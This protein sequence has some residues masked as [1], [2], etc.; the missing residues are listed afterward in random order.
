MKETFGVE[1]GVPLVPAIEGELRRV[2]RA[3]RVVGRERR[4]LV[5]PSCAGLARGVDAMSGLR[6]VLQRLGRER[7]ARRDVAEVTDHARVDA[8]VRHRRFPERADHVDVTRR[9]D[10]REERAKLGERDPRKDAYRA[11]AALEEPVRD[12]GERSLRLPENVIERDETERAHDERDHRVSPALHLAARVERAAHRRLGVARLEPLEEPRDERV[13]PRGE[14]GLDLANARVVARHHLVHRRELGVLGLAFGLRRGAALVGREAHRGEHDALHLAR[15]APPSLG[16]PREGLVDE[17]HELGRQRRIHRRDGGHGLARGEVER[18]LLGP[19]PVDA[20]A[21]DERVEERANREQIRAPVDAIDAA[22]GLL[23]RHVRWRAER[24]AERLVA[25]VPRAFFARHAEVE[26]LD[27]AAPRHEDVRGLEIAMDDADRVTR[28]EAIEDALGDVERLRDGDCLA[29]ATPVIAHRLALE[30]LHDEE[31]LVALG[32]VV[33]DHAHA[34]GVADLVRDV[35]L[36]QEALDDRAIARELDVHHLERGALTVAMR[37]REHR[38]D[39]AHAEERVELPLAADG[40]AHP[41]DGG[42]LLFRACRYRVRHELECATEK[43][44]RHEAEPSRAGREHNR[45]ASD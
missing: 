35:R 42:V 38:R 19:A 24:E 27:R 41:R 33:V 21:R 4:R 44:P 17:A 11:H 5:G 14:D 43:A 6:F 31:R 37:R 29:R 25:L 26:Q 20:A 18:L 16:L 28:G 30:Q 39:A 7:L 12:R 1:L 2:D 13:V 3:D 8:D 40:R 9:R 15:A 23:G 45:G 10:A 22:V 36:A 34:S 32:R